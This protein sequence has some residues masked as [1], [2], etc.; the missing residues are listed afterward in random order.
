MANS[1]E[2]AFRETR[3]DVIE[4]SY[5]LAPKLARISPL[6]AKA[7]EGC[8]ETMQCSAGLGSI[9]LA[10]IGMSSRLSYRQ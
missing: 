8:T 5:Y 7:L 1:F 2:S 9:L 4:L 3:L 6:I 10:A